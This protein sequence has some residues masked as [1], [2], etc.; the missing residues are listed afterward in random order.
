MAGE[1]AEAERC[2]DE[3][4]RLYRALG[5]NKIGEAN[6]LKARARLELARHGGLSIR[7][8]RHLPRTT[9]ALRRIRKSFKQAERAYRDAGMATG[10]SSVRWHIDL[11]DILGAGHS[12]GA[13]RLG[14]EAR[15]SLDRARDHLL[16]AELQNTAGNAAAALE[17]YQAAEAEAV[18]AS[19]TTFAVAAAAG[20][21]EMAYAL[22][23]T[24]ATAR[25]LRSA[26]QYAESIRAAV[27][28]GTARRHIANTVRAHYEHAMYLAARIDDGE[29]ALE[30]AERLRTER[31]AGL[32]RRGTRALPP[33]LAGLL[34][35]IGRINDALTV[36]DPSLRGVRSAQPIEDLADRHSAELVARRDELRRML[37][38]RTNDLFADTF[39]AEPVRVERLAAI[40]EHVL[41]I[42]PVTTNDGEY[43][44]SVWRSP[45]GECT[46][47]IVAV[48]EQI[49]MLRTILTQQDLLDRLNLRAQSLQP[50]GAVIPD[51]AHQ[52]LLDTRALLKLVIVPTGWLWAVPFA[53]VPLGDDSFLVD[54]ADIVLSP[55]LRF[56]MALADRERSADVP[57]AAVS[58]LDPEANFTAPELDALAFHPAGHLALTD[59]GAV[60]DAFVRGGAQWQTAV[61]AAHGDREPGLAHAILAGSATILTAADFLDSTAQAPKTISLASCHSGFPGGEDH[62]EPLG[63]ALTA[64][65]A[66]ATNVVSAHF[67]IDSEDG[68]MRQCLTRLYTGM[69]DHESISAL[70]GQILRDPVMRGPN[71]STWLYRW[72]ALTVIGTH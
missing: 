18:H 17:A 55:S 2:L 58:W 9:G 26:V 44:V 41:L 36:R 61:L 29:L 28:S 3:Y 31:L 25:H 62:H 1:F 33:D 69:P 70:L 59:L 64:L 32:L 71:Q 5:G 6:L 49:S 47:Q 23:D 43:L 35:E 21:A 8:L 63:L 14:G 54:H 68:P 24:D 12:K 37:A 15:D 40:E 42:V 13:R 56:L 45:S 57:K 4:G 46:A 72:A 48:S 51:S 11:I 66:G 65:A 22:G 67:E 52:E 10:R 16:Y 60:K 7:S 53:A 39:G 38:D 20:S 34:S 50:L 19:A 30:I 27:A